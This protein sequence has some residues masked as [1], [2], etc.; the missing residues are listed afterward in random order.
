VAEAP[1]APASAVATFT[2]QIT[3]KKIRLLVYNVQASQVR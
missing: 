3:N 2:T 1:T